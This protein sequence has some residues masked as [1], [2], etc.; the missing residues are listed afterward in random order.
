[1][2]TTPCSAALKVVLG[3]TFMMYF[4]AHSY[5]WNVEG[6]N[7]NDYHTFFK[8]IYDELWIAVDMIAE[9]IRTCDDYAPVSIE[10][11]YTYKTIQEDTGLVV[12]QQKFANLLA[13]NDQVVQSLNK[14]FEIANAEKNQG[15]MN[16]VADRLDIHAKHA[17]MI[18]SLSK[19]GE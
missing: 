16:F 7:F 9:H 6:K 12:N 5:H 18:R 14:L 3:N 4:K 1:M 13:A 10:E 17:W 11:L 2:A 15:L 8:T 19:S